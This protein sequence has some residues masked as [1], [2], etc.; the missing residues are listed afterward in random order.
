MFLSY[1]SGFWEFQT[2]WFRA[3]KEEKE[4]E[5][6][7]TALVLIHPDLSNIAIAM[8]TWYLYAFSRLHCVWTAQ[9]H[10]A[11]SLICNSLA[12]DFDNILQ[13]T[14]CVTIQFAV[15]KIRTSGTSTMDSQ[16][17]SQLPKVGLLLAAKLS[18]PF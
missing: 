11:Y 13:V 2:G 10:L 7:P 14:L 18:A 4:L 6:V 12:C 8:P 17:G 16:G 3:I 9:D 1:G 15:Q 5:Q